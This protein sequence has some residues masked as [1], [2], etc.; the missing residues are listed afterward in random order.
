MENFANWAKFYRRWHGPFTNFELMRCSQFAWE[1]TYGGMGDL[2]LCLLQT[3]MG[4]GY[5]NHELFCKQVLKPTLRI[6]AGWQSQP[7]NIQVISFVK[8]VPG[9]CSAGGEWPDEFKAS[10]R[11]QRL[12]ADRPAPDLLFL[13]GSF[14]P[15]S[16]PAAFYATRST[17]LCAK[18]FGRL[19]E[20]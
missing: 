16:D 9:W 18:R 5:V 8:L 20:E 1:R 2:Y 3:A 7:E 11:A 6:R 10:Y 19:S 14:L 17:A 13:L 12:C 4:M 15:V